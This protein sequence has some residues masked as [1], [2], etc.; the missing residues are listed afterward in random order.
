VE[1]YH[2]DFESDI[3]VTS[4]PTGV[5]GAGNVEFNAV[6]TGWAEGAEALLRAPHWGPLSGW[7]SYAWSDDISSPDGQSFA[8][9]DFSQ[10]EAGNAVVNAALPWGFTLGARLHLAS[11]IPYTPIQSRSYDAATGT[12]TPT[13]GGTNSERLPTYE[14]LDLRLEKG[15]KAS[16]SWWRSLNVYI[17]VINATDADNI[18]SVTYK[19][20][21]SDIERVEQF[22]RFFFGGADFA[23]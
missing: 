11:G 20:D 23:F 19:S 7:I 21:Y 1:A 2:K 6:D 8:P 15:W 9:A 18:T 12:W 14:R 5:S 10:P 22:P 13:F 4:A 3:P 16:G 17:D